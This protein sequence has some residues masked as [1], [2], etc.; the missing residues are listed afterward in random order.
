MKW[1]SLILAETVIV[2]MCFSASEE[3][4]LPLANTI[5]LEGV[6]GRIDHL[7]IDEKGGRLFIAALGNN[8][9]EIVDL[10]AGKRAGTIAGLREPQGVLYIPELGR[11]VV[12]N[13]SD[14]SVRFYDG[15]TYQP[16]KTID[17]KRDADNLRYDAAAKRIYVG[18]GD[19]AIGVLNPETG[20]RIA[21]IPLPGHPESFQLETN[22]P[23]LFVNVPKAH[24]VIVADR[25]AAKVI[26]AWPIKPKDNFPMAL[27]EQNRRLFIGC[28]NPAGLLVL[29]MDSGKQMAWL[30]SVGDADDLFYALKL[31]KVYITGG[32]GAIDV[33]DQQAPD[34]YK[35]ISKTSTPPG[36]RTSF[37]DAERKSLYVAVPK[38]LRTA[39]LRVYRLPD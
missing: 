21:D 25:A 19:G 27:D 35:L 13:G 17:F 24:Q 33:F 26:A 11:I 28:R 8:S 31:Q 32:A 14:G 2:S 6:S 18:Y 3:A 30:E 9:L 39:E 12:A 34:V 38:I 10:A 4:P 22:G 7:A 5:P 15:A 37:L 1:F 20:D 36:T 29:D 16:V 23:R